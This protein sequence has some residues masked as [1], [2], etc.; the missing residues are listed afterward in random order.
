LVFFFREVMEFHYRME[1]ITAVQVLFF[2]S[3]HTA[4]C[5]MRSHNSLVMCLVTKMTFHK[6]SQIWLYCSKSQF[7]AC[8]SNGINQ[9]AHLRNNLHTISLNNTT[10]YFH[11]LTFN[12]TCFGHRWPSSGVPLCQTCYTAFS[13]VQS[14]H[15]FEHLVIKKFLQHS[16]VVHGANKI[17]CETR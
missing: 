7:L 15:V 8:N 1:M 13:I 12:T 4:I 10:I 6:L 3:E 5:F 9:N 11:Y 2:I 14:M 16:S 17:S